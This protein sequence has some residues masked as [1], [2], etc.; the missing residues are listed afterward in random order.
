MQ[1]LIFALS[2]VIVREKLLTSKIALSI[3][4]KSNSNHITFSITEV[5]FLVQEI[6]KPTYQVQ[7]LAFPYLEA[8][9][10]VHSMKRSTLRRKIETV[11]F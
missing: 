10:V 6:K 4:R 3:I 11:G 7:L 8:K 1:C 5:L 9:F 2:G